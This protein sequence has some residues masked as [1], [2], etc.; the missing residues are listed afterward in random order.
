MNLCIVFQK[1]LKLFISVSWALMFQFLFPP[2]P[3]YITNL[4]FDTGQLNNLR[5]VYL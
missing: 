4:V 5:I 3:E 1:L 2:I